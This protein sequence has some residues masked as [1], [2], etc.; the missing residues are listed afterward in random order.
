MQAG[1][2]LELE[3]LGLLVQLGQDGLNT[4]IKIWLI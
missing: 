3:A 1:I 4:I 2:C